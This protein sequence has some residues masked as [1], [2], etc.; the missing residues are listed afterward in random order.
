MRQHANM[1]HHAKFCG[2]RS[3]RCCY[4]AIFQD[5]GR[6]YL[7]FSKCRNFRGRKGQEGQNVSPCQISRQSVKLFLRYGDLSIFQDGGRR[8]LGFSKC[9]NFRRV[10]GEEGQNASLCRISR[11]LV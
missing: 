7:G 3:N 1:C 11:W 8:N 6:C 5:G 9:R 4:M 2:D 10:K